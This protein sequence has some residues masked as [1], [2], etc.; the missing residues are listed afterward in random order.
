MILGVDRVVSAGL[1]HESRL[2]TRLS[3]NPGLLASVPTWPFIWAP[4][5]RSGP[6]A[7]LQTRKGHS[8][9]AP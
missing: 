5:G 6:S 7:G 8:C 3:G 2:G 9:K 4:L 1:T